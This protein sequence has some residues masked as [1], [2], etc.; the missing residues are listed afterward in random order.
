MAPRDPIIATPPIQ[1][2]Q[3][4]RRARRAIVGATVPLGV[5][6]AGGREAEL[7]TTLPR[8]AFRPHTTAEKMVNLLKKPFFKSHLPPHPFSELF[9]W[10][11]HSG[12][13]FRL[14]FWCPP[15][16]YSTPLVTCEKVHKFE[17][18]FLMKIRNLSKLL[19]G[20]LNLEFLLF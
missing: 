8:H 6:R 12:P 18:R 19:T 20:S 13:F 10:L 4:S 14:G 9:S 16:M 11:A 15:K 7:Q 5:L 1:R 3:T 17:I 2:S